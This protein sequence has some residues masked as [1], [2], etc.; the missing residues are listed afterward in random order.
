MKKNKIKKILKL[1]KLTKFSIIL[2]K[3]SLIKNKWD[4]NKTIKY[5]RVKENKKKQNIKNLKYGIVYSMVNE[6]NKLG[7]LIQLKVKTEEVSYNNIL[8]KLLKKILKISLYYKCKNIKEILKSKYNENISIKNEL[9]DKS[10]MF[11]DNIIIN[12]FFIIKS[13]YIYNYNHYNNKISSLIGYIKI[14]KNKKINKKIIKYISLDIIGNESLS[15]KKDIKY[16]NKYYNSN[17][18]DPFFLKRINLNIKQ[19]L[20]YFKNIKIYDYYIINMVS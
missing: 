8:L 12:K 4:I 19:F 14:N 7:H 1:R 9:L 3:K 11:K 17:N 6:D 2:C 20:Y 15:L 18:I 10:I 13:D 16:I 5:L